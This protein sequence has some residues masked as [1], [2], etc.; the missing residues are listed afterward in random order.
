MRKKVVITGI[1]TATCVLAF[2]PAELW[3]FSRH[4]GEVVIGA[5]T[6]HF[7]DKA[8]FLVNCL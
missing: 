7:I 6:V 4:I 1:F 3:A 5:Y 2:W 8:T